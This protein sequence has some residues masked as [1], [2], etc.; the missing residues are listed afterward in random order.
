ML[1]TSSADAVVIL[2]DLDGGVGGG[3]GAEQGQGR[4]PSVHKKIEVIDANLLG[5]HP[6]VLTAHR[7]KMLYSI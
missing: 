2:W 1:A 6:S 5:Y 4:G 3:A 7:I